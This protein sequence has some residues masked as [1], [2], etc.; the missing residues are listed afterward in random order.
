[1]STIQRFIKGDYQRFLPWQ[2]AKRQ[3]FLVCF[4]SLNSLAK[5]R[6]LCVCQLLLGQFFYDLIFPKI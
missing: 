5:N 4:F 2:P 3:K 6:F 1:M